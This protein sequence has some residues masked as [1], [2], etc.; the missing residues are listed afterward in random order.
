[1]N[2]Y[3][4][5]PSRLGVRPAPALVQQLLVGAFGWMGAGLALTAAVAYLVTTSP[6]FLASIEAI[7]L[8]LIIGQVILAVVI[9]AAINKMSPTASLALFFIYAATMGLTIGLIVSMYTGES[10]AAAFIS[11]A[12]MFG[13]AAVFG[14]TTKRDLSGLGGI[15]SMAVIGLVVAMLVNMLLNSSPLGWLIS[16]VGVGLFTVLT[17]YDVQK[18]TSGQYAA[19]T[20]SA[21]RASILAALR[22]YLDFVNLFLFLL[23]LFGGSRR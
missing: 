10:V 19:I 2:G 9:Q 5:N 4:I 16:I 13:G 21:E 6:S 3:P 1:M 17:A 8:P 18:I 7:W 23:R 14:I 11:S 20:S 22:L 15:A 12:A